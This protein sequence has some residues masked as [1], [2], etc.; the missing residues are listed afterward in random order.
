MV[1]RLNEQEHILLFTVHHIVFD[2][3]STAILVN[4]LAAL[5]NE[6]VNSMPTELPRLQIQYSDYA[7]WQ[8]RI[9]QSAEFQMHLTYWKEHLANV[10]TQINLPVDR[11]YP[12]TPSLRGKRHPFTLDSSLV[13]AL[14]LLSEQEKCTL[15]MTLMA[16]VQI[17][18]YRY[19][20]QD[21]FLIGIPS[22]GRAHVETEPLIGL[23][24]QTLMQQ[25]D[26]SG[27][28]TF[29]A[30]LQRVRHATI[31]AYTHQHIPF[32]QLVKIAQPQRSR[33]TTPLIQIAFSP[34]PSL[35]EQVYGGGI[36]FRI[37]EKDNGKA[38]FDLTF[39]IRETEQSV[40]GSLEYNTDIFDA[41]TIERM[42][43][44]WSV[45]L[46]AAVTH[47]D[48]IITHLPML[49][50]QEIQHYQQ[51][52]YNTTTHDLQNLFVH[53]LFEQQVTCVPMAIA[54]STEQNCLTYQEVNQRANQ[55]ARYLLS[56]GVGPEI[57]VGLAL[58]RSADT[59]ISILAILKAG[60]AYVP[61]DTEYP[62]ER[63]AFMVTDAHLSL[64]ITRE[65]FRTRLPTI[66]GVCQCF[67][68]EHIQTQITH[69]DSTNVS[70][71][72]ERDN[73]AYLIYTSGS[74]G[75]PKGVMIPH[76]GLV[77]VAWAQK[78]V[79]GIHSQEKVLQ[80]ASLSFDISI[81]EW[82]MALTH[83]GTLHIC[84]H[85]SQRMGSGLLDYLRKEHIT[86][87]TLPPS[88]V[89]SLPLAPLN[90]LHTLIVGAEASSAQLVEQWSPGRMLY[91]AYGPTEATIWS[92]VA[93]CVANGKTPAI[94]Y[95]IS[96]TQVYI[97][98]SAMQLV[99]TSVPGELYLGGIGLARGYQGQAALTA[100]CFV[101]HPY[102]QV[103]GE[104][105]YKTGDLVRMNT[106]GQLEFLGRLDQ[107]VKLRGYRIELTEIE[108]ILRKHPAIR[109]A[110]VILREDT[111]ANKRLVAYVTASEQWQSSSLESLRNYLKGQVPHYM[112]PAAIMPLNS[113]PVTINGK[114]NRQCLP[115][116]EPCAERN[117]VQQPPQ[118]ELEHYIAGIWQE[119]LGLDTINIYE[120]FFDLGGHSLLLL[121]V[122]DKLQASM[123]DVL[124]ITDLFSYPSIHALATHLST[125]TNEQT[126]L[127]SIND[128][129][130][131]KKVVQRQQK[132]ITRRTK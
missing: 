13:H 81:Y 113:L 14:R 63:L 49:T 47:P 73:L 110:V 66:T 93:H 127:H 36:V 10:P 116:P 117:T 6:S 42:V 39:E 109:E 122:W 75:K 78:C 77:N 28:P 86:A 51:E 89:A 94:G 118:T 34:Q 64:L 79:Y 43:N 121:Q 120:N 9:L 2:G 105:L 69:Y 15:V 67:Y 88:I 18:L 45:L 38:K 128:R 31:D 54:I 76:H 60:G 11:P 98:D 92:T 32:Q 23:F 106:K 19:T 30:L 80:L 102:S 82:I 111:P 126:T 56:I 114:L 59:I 52:M 27:N 53:N 58:E 101:P 65:S 125:Q 72:I 48:Q 103:A 87:A 41:T 95:P 37:E 132:Y 16:T 8:Q 112:V 62:P 124:T 108:H 57:R 25:A 20:Q 130:Q 17:L 21:T 83:G 119:V 29:R 44:H 46:A 3:W 97:L 70:V 68:L 85:E 24:V 74:T 131:R 55:L 33:N 107:Q 35:P 7:C 84:A 4:E 100:E 129:V 1:L 123:E 22:G 5:Y 91:N 90:D 96:N 104:R 26:L 61:L 71:P 12:A 50:E 115:V 99:P 40:T